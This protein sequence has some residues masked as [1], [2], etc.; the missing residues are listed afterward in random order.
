MITL[1]ELQRHV[2]KT[3]VEKG[4]EEDTNLDRKLLLAVGELTEA[5]NELRSGHG[6]REV[7]HNVETHKPEGFLV[8]L[9]DALIRIL[10]IASAVGVKEHEF[11]DI[12]LDKAAYNAT[13]P[14]KHGKEF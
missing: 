2:W 6:P 5:Q 4:F 7:Y 3:Q 13:R 14:F 12:I 1:D 11:V 9:A 8:E 10:N